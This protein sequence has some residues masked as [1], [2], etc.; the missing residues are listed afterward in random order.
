[1]TRALLSRS[2]FR[3]PTC[4]QHL[5]SHNVSTIYPTTWNLPADPVTEKKRK[6]HQHRQRQQ[7]HDSSNFDDSKRNVRKTFWPAADAN[8]FSRSHVDIRTRAHK[9]GFPS[10]LTRLPVRFKSNPT[11]IQVHWSSQH[12]INRNDMKWLDPVE[13]PSSG[14]VLDRYVAWSDGSRPL[15]WSANTYGSV[16]PFVCTTAQRLL[17][18]GIRLALEEN[19]YDRFGMK[20]VEH[21]QPPPINDPS[22]LYGTMRISCSNP[23]DLCQ[24]KFPEILSIGRT[25]VPALIKQLKAEQGKPPLRSN[26]QSWAPRRDQKRGQSTS[27]VLW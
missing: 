22:N 7:S 11:N 17:N 20:L 13:H 18:R 14:C 21:G 9:I 8:N 2:L 23:T 26:N 24:L 25:I 4:A 16:S 1:M 10:K 5:L 6:S 12:L 27:N 3:L 19:G 15:W